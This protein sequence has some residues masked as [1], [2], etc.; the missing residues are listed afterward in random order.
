MLQRNLTA[1]LIPPFIFSVIFFVCFLLTFQ[2]FR[3]TELVVNKSV[4]FKIIALLVGHIAVSFLPVS[5]PIS[6]LFATLFTLGKMS[7]DSEIVAMRSFGLSYFTIFLPFLI[8]SAVVGQLTY[9]L[10]RDII[11]YSSRELKNTVVKLTSKGVLSNIKKGQFY[12][13]IPD[14]ILFADDVQNDGK[15]LINVFIQSQSSEVERVIMA[16]KGI[17]VRKE[18]PGEAVTGLHLH[19]YD[20][21]LLIRDNQKNEL[22]KIIY[23]EYDFPIF[24][25]NFKSSFVDRESTRT[26]R[27]LLISLD[28]Y[29]NKITDLKIKSKEH[30]EDGSIFEEIKA[31]KISLMRGELEYWSRI[32]S[33]FQCVSFV[34]LAFS[35][36]IKRPRGKSKST[37]V[38]VLAILS[39]YYIFYFIG[40]S[41]TRKDMMPAIV[42][43]FFPIFVCTALAY[44]FYRK[45]DW[46]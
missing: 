31:V 10:N 27:E 22:R 34:F 3:F 5:I 29:K 37:I 43:A 21:N 7:E 36:G 42:T 1:G 40:T 11:P 23:H 9:Y 45:L 41:L 39:I 8:F 46:Q 20:G 33:L 38:P 30:P 15:E 14:V 19:L 26:N 44:A 6:L 2:L 12:I 28:K 35:F 13:E 24:T 17:L 16:K 32:S 18:I 4:D 25:N